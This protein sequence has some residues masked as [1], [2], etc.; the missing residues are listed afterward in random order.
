MKN[1]VL[2]LLILFPAMVGAQ[3]LQGMKVED[4][5]KMMQKMQTCM[6]KVDRGKLKT[7]EQLG[8]KIE[9]E[10][11]S[12]CASGERDQAQ[13]KAMAF[14]QKLQKNEMVKT[15][16]ECSKI[17]QDVM[18]MEPILEQKDYSKHHVCD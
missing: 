17:M 6:Q 1:A 5:Q 14:G 10:V 15:M 12:L 9:A 11:K 2:V 7:L 16:R 4:L 13:A 3:N 8:N 18:P